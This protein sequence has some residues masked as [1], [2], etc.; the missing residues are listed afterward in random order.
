MERGLKQKVF[1]SYLRETISSVVIV[2]HFVIQNTKE[3]YFLV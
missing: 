1:S 2:T 3:N